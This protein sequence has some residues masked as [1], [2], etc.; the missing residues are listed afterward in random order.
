MFHSLVVKE[1]VYKGQRCVTLMYLLWVLRNSHKLEPVV[2][3][4]FNPVLPLG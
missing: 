4:L 3:F 2:T 1:H